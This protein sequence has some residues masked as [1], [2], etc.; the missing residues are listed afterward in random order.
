MPCS[1]FDISILTNFNNLVNTFFDGV[2]NSVK[3]I[4]IIII[5][6]YAL[7]SNSVESGNI[8]TRGTENM[9]TVK[10]GRLNGFATRMKQARKQAGMTRAEF[11]DAV[12]TPIATATAW[13]FETGEPS[14]PRLAQ[15]CRILNISADWLLGLPGAG[16][17]QSASA[18]G[19]GSAA[20]VNGN[21]TAAHCRDCATVSRLLGIIETMQG[22]Q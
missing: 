14:I 21:A 15:I 13:E 19:D 17:A 5:W 16:A 3:I 6:H 9:K 4:D 1:I 2:I 20:A 7:L 22:K 18:S 10:Q 8:I 12:A 11:A